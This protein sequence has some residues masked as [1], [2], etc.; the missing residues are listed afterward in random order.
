MM[1]KF[2]LPHRNAGNPLYN[3]DI[4][5]TPGITVFKDDTDAPEILPENEWYK[6]DVL[7]CAAPNL[8]NADIYDSYT[9][10]GYA[11][12]VELDELRNLIK[13][14]VRRI[15]EV[16]AH[17]EN[18]VLML[19]AFGCGAFRNPPELVAD[20]FREVTKEYEHCFEIIEFA[21]FHTEREAKNFRAFYHAFMNDISAAPEA[22]SPQL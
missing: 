2:Y 21:V 8:R 11:E 12:A 14:R 19:G 16:A 13:K 1:T 7:T 22:A 10:H 4:I 17:E 20:V 5:Y 9:S 18:E 15:V 3:D 6:V